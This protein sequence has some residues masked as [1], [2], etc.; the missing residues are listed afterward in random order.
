MPK[1]DYEEDDA[2]SGRRGPPPPPGPRKIRP[3]NR[4]PRDVE[5]EPTEDNVITPPPGFQPPTGAGEEF[6]LV[7][8]FRKEPDGKLCMT[9]LGDYDMDYGD[10]EE[11]PERPPDYKDMAGE[12]AGAGM[13]AGG[14]AGNPAAGGGPGM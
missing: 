9:K 5:E 8:T 12:M 13:M 6:D 3:P 11:G 1:R 10:E 14:D 7:C 2:P 4:P